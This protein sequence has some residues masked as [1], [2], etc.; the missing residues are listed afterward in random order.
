M[1]VRRAFQDSAHLL[2]DFEL[3][4]SSLAGTSVSAVLAF[5]PVDQQKRAHSHP[6]AQGGAKDHT[7]VVYEFLHVKSSDFE[8]SMT[9]LLTVR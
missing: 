8:G 9:R 1:R 7:S 6:L 3:S 2:Y 4:F 5:A